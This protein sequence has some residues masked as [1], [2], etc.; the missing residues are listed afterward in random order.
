MTYSKNKY[1]GDLVE[2]IRKPFWLFNEA[3]QECS[4]WPLILI[5][6]TWLKNLETS[7]WTCWTD[8]IIEIFSVVLLKLQYI[9]DRG[10][11][12]RQLPRQRDH[13]FRPNNYWLSLHYRAIFV[14][15]APVSHQQALKL[16]YFFNVA[17]HW[18]S[19]TCSVVVVKLNHCLLP[20]SDPW[21]HWKFLCGLLE[22]T[23]VIILN[24]LY[25]ITE[26]IL[27]TFLK[28]SLWPF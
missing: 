24:D 17:C 16:T 8:G 7:S 9:R 15:A 20:S 2:I 27:Q 28:L 14:V 5:R 23:S 10:G 1:F 25:T 21:R 13:V 4:P 6:F 3:C 18:S 19:K 12:I 26:I 22:M 11:L